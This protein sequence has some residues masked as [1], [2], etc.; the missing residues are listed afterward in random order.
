MIIVPYKAEHLDKLDLQE[1][2]QYLA[3]YLKPDLRKL[4]EGEYSFTGFDGDKVVGCAGLLP[5]WENRGIVWAY[6]ASDS[7]RHF[8]AIHKA[9]KRFLDAAPFNRIE[10]TVDAE[11]EPGH[12]WVKM[13]GFK[14]EAPLM[15]KY[16][17]NDG[18]SA[19]YARVR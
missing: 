3:V 6:L 16:R 15:R 2:Q 13:L 17:P 7:G 10:A 5:Q 19:L 18:D 14:L 4:L 9:V 11:F 1:G 8:P 12:R